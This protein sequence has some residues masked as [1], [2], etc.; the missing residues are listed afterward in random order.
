MDESFNR[1]FRENSYFNLKNKNFTSDLKKAI[2]LKALPKN[3]IPTIPKA[4]EF[5]IL[6]K[7]QT[8]HQ[9]YS[10]LSSS[11]QNINHYNDEY[12]LRTISMKR[13]NSIEKQKKSSFMEEIIKKQKS[14]DSFKIKLEKSYPI[15]LEILNGKW[16]ESDFVNL[17]NFKE[18]LKG[19]DLQKERLSKLS[20]IKSELFDY[21]SKFSTFSE[22]KEAM[23]TIHLVFAEYDKIID[24][25]QNWISHVC[26]K[27]ENNRRVL[28]DKKNKEI[29]DLNQF[30]NI[31][32]DILNLDLRISQKKQSDLEMPFENEKMEKEWH[33]KLN[34]LKVRFKTDF[35][36]SNFLNTIENLEKFHGEIFK[37]ISTLK[38]AKEILQIDLNNIIKSHESNQTLKATFEVL[39][40]RMELQKNVIAPNFSNS[41]DYL[42]KFEDIYKKNISELKEKNERLELETKAMKDKLRSSSTD[43]MNLTK[44]KLKN[45]IIQTK[46]QGTQ[47][48]YLSF[49]ENQGD[50]LK[51]NKF[52][53]ALQHN[54]SGFNMPTGCVFAFMNLI[55]SDKIL[56][57]YNQYMEFRPYPNFKNFALQWF[58]TNFGNQTYANLILNDFFAN[59]TEIMHQYERCEIFNNL[60]GIKYNSSENPSP[61][62]FYSSTRCGRIFL[63]ILDFVNSKIKNIQFLSPFLPLNDTIL[64]TQEECIKT[65]VYMCESEENDLLVQNDLVKQ[66]IAV[67]EKRQIKVVDRKNRKKNSISESE[68]KAMNAY[69]GLMISV[70]V[71]AKYFFDS[72][73][74]SFERQINEMVNSLKIIQSNR[75][76]NDFFS[77]DF[78]KTLIKFFPNTTQPFAEECFM[79]FIYNNSHHEISSIKDLMKN[80][81]KKLS[82]MPYSKK[83]YLDFEERNYGVYKEKYFDFVSSIVVV[84]HLYEHMVEKIKN[85]EVK[86]DNLYVLHEQFKKE[87]NRFPKNLENQNRYNT[88]FSGNDKKETV[89]RVESLWRLFR[90][91]TDILFSRS[92]MLC[93]FKEEKKN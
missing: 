40:K 76:H 75:K 84:T 31:V 42:K 30:Y 58:L 83:F 69:S 8:F 87:L 33:Y 17:D 66:F 52:F 60:C 50:P 41:L 38:S 70:D 88:I 13:D 24:L 29:F 39:N 86:N 36:Q 6:Q 14:K 73:N 16:D 25:F 7:S 47:V 91:M 15:L 82:D 4:N 27:T 63:K 74:T 26:Q 20:S 53:K 80:F 81:E 85:E 48:N 32:I 19:V 51:T 43:I 59:L 62:Y 68:N 77:D 65:L 18:I 64:L 3:Y 56:Y 21:F 61:N 2:L 78:S 35:P 72:L 12:S 34:Q 57:D 49:D 93:V 5:S 79:E 92:E 28:E 54:K 90:S 71:L 89:E 37:T 55:L 10:S 45:V 9:K 67:I 11:K 1:S 22:N 23:D 46:H 44:K